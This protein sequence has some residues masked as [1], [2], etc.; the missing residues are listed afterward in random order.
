MRLVLLFGCLSLVSA[1]EWKQGDRAI[2][3][4]NCDFGESGNSA[5]TQRMITASLQRLEEMQL[6]SNEQKEIAVKQFHVNVDNVVVTALSTGVAIW[7]MY[8]GQVVITLLSTS[9]TWIQVD[10]LVVLQ[11]KATDDDT[12]SLDAEER[13]FDDSH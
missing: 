5:L 12:E 11:G 6:I 4:E 10:P 3:A 1:I 8:I 7:A 9:A 13:L 2:W